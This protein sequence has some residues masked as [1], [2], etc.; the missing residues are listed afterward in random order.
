M[1]V[2]VITYD[3]DYEGPDIHGPFEAV[4]DAQ[5]YAE[6]YRLRNNLPG[7]ATS[8]NNYAWTEAGWYFGIVQPTRDSA[9]KLPGGKV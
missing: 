3:G 4:Q 8:E 2:L 5:A 6:R 9:D 1:F 7:P